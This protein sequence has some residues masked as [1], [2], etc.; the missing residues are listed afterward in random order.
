MTTAMALRV[1]D[2]FDRFNADEQ[3]SLMRYFLTWDEA[4]RGA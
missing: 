2:I 4:L 3:V 1:L